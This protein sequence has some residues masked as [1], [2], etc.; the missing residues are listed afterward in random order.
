MSLENE[1]KP[2]KIHRD[3]DMRIEYLDIAATERTFDL[4]YTR[5]ALNVITTGLIIFR[6]FSPSSDQSS[7]QETDFIQDLS[8]KNIGNVGLI[9]LAFFAFGIILLIISILRRTFIGVGIG[10]RSG[11]FLLDKSKLNRY[12]NRF[13]RIFRI[14]SSGAEDQVE[15]IELSSPGSNN[16]KDS[17]IPASD[18]ATS[19]FTP[20]KEMAFSTKPQKRKAYEKVNHG[21]NYVDITSNPFGT[22]LPEGFYHWSMKHPK[23][24]QST[25]PKFNQLDT[26]DSV[27]QVDFQTIFSTSGLTVL[28]TTVLTACL[29]VV[30]LI[31]IWI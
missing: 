7:N 3:L 21:N 30:V 12:I 8:Q 31:L 27:D 5:T 16:P 20:I 29:E 6:V 25:S 9:G 23:L 1:K 4:A 18:T 11:G 28:S 10:S 13:K 22:D 17:S 24:A 19:T 26:F 2:G 14:G 15:E